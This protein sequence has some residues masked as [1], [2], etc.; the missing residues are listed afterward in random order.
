M[1]RAKDPLLDPD[2]LLKPGEVA[3]LMRVDPKTVTRWA[4]A[5]RMESVRTPG[6][7]HRFR[8]SLVRRLL[9]KQFDPDAEGK[10]ADTEQRPPSTTTV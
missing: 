1:D 9:D 6:G 7:H 10:K 4:K 5:G 2:R 3:E 8:E